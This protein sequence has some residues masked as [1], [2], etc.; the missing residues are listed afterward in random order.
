MK[1]L[2]K[3]QKTPFTVE[4][5]AELLEKVKIKAKQNGLKIRQVIEHYLEVFLTSED[6][7]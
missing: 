6:L 3:E 1:R 7:K 2:K 5:E 4:I